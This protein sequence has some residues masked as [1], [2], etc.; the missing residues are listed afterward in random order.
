MKKQYKSPIIKNHRLTPKFFGGGFP[1]K[2][3]VAALVIFRFCARNKKKSIV[4]VSSD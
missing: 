1:L 4:G 2:G 3:Y